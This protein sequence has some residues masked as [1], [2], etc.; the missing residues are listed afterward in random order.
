M[1]RETMWVLPF[2]PL[3]AAA[4]IGQ[5][6]YIAAHTP[7]AGAPGRRRNRPARL[8]SPW[9]CIRGAAYFYDG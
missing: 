9:P 4:S 6:G 5:G 1:N 2:L 8:H 7:W 3:L